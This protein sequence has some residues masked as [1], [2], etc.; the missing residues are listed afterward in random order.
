MP[1]AKIQL[2]NAAFPKSF[3]AACSGQLHSRLEP[4]HLQPSSRSAFWAMPVRQ[5]DNPLQILSH[6]YTATQ[7]ET[8]EGS[9][10]DLSRSYLLTSHLPA[11]E[12][13]I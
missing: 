13:K 5:K 3:N 1:L 6:F 9:W 4:N 12:M 10:T 11:L 7:S 8:K 2:F